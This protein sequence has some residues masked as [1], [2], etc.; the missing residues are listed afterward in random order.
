MGVWSAQGCVECTGVCGVHRGV[1]SAQGRV[2][3]TGACGVH[4]G[5]WRAQGRVACTGV[6]GDM[7]VSERACASLRRSGMPC[8]MALRALV[9]VVVQRQQGARPVLALSVEGCQPCGLLP[10]RAL[11]NQ[12]IEWM[13]S[14]ELQLVWWC[15]QIVWTNCGSGH[16][17]AVCAAVWPYLG[18][19]VV[20]ATVH[21]VSG[22]D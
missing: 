5:V 7:C 1:W 12:R 22:W 6:C 17:L 14:E 3:C 21:C 11:I 4:R 16:R 2:E 19:P 8:G 9:V 10:R 13:R 20:L 18:R 15:G